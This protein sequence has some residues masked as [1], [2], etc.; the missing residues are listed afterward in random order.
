M[1]KGQLWYIK[2]AYRNGKADWKPVYDRE[3]DDKTFQIV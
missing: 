3:N 1:N 2:F